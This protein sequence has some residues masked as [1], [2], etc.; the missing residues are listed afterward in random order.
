MLFS[1]LLTGEQWISNCSNLFV[2]QSNLNTKSREINLVS[3]FSAKSYCIYYVFNKKLL[4][5]AA[6]HRH[7]QC[8]LGECNGNYFT[9]KGMNANLNKVKMYTQL[10]L[11]QYL[12]KPNNFILDPHI[13]CWPRC[14][15]V[16]VITSSPPHPKVR[17]SMQLQ[18]LGIKYKIS[19][20]N[21]K[22]KKKNV[23]VKETHI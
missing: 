15:V 12:L 5:V 1:L 18:S 3:L 20:R 14:C 17:V 11:S 19:F 10:L 22:R 13:L 4:L 6:L 23:N 8:V 16:L 21:K 7:W 2:S 9:L